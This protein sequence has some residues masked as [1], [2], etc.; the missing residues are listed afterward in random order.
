MDT[1]A[2]TCFRCAPAARRHV[3][4]LIC[5]NLRAAPGPVGPAGA[6]RR[7]HGAYIPSH[8]GQVTEQCFF[9][10]PEICDGLDNDCNGF[11]D[12]REPPCECLDGATRPCGTDIGVCEFGTETCASGSWGAC[13]GGVGPTT[14]SMD[15]SVDALCNVLDDNCDG[16]TDEGCG[17]V[18]PAIQACGTDIGECTSGTQGCQSDGT[19]GPCMGEVGPQPETCNG[20]D[21]DCNGLTDDGLNPPTAI[22]C[23]VDPLAEFI[24]SDPNSSMVPPLEMV[25]LDGTQSSDPDA[26]PL[27]YF[28]NIASAP[29]GG[30]AAISDPGIA[31]PVLIPDLPGDF[32]VCLTVT[33]TTSC[34]SAEA[35]VTVHAGP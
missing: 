34:S 30:T 15:E 13:L 21:D 12:D 8:A 5:P 6:P 18:P 31:L 14:T 9:D 17:C 16:Q 35:C 3:A 20:L 2:D 11:V 28:W 1:P 22:A 23:W 4:A 7:R 26:Q 24:C 25:Q 32:V 19:F 10:P 27:A 33:D 29:P